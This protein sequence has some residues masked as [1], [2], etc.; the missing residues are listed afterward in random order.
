MTIEFGGFQFTVEEF[1]GLIVFG[2]AFLVQLFYLILLT[3]FIFSGKQK[4]KVPNLPSISIIV[5]SRNYLEQLQELL[6]TLLTQD[7][8]DYEIVVVDDCS[9]DGTD[10]FLA[11]LKISHGNLKTTKIIQETDF[12]NAL[13]I[14]IG[15]RASS[16]EWLVYLSPLCRIP[17]NQWLRNYAQRLE[18]DKEVS[19]GYMHFNQ[20]KGNYK[21]WLR[22]ENFTSFLLSGAGQSCGVAMPVFEF[23][24]AY[25]RETF[26]DLRGFAAVL[27]SPFSENE[28]FINKIGTRKNTVVLNNKIT[29]IAFAGEAEWIDLVEFKKKQLMLRRKFSAGQRFFRTLNLI[30]RLA[31]TASLIVLLIVSPL[32]FWILGTWGFLLLFEMTMIAVVTKKIG[33]KNFLP[34]LLIYRAFLPLIN[35]YFVI[36]QLFTGQKRKWK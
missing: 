1:I 23:N 21:S 8:P 26:L 29:P 20:A 9:T 12:P 11:E 33:E 4:N 10:W 7:Y 35:I 32:L 28:L 16:K 2:L 14:T 22:F 6:P 17:D 25:R 24:M 18:P 34:M 19:I 27:D 3:N 30:S 15:V 36:V 5:T 31:L 13:A